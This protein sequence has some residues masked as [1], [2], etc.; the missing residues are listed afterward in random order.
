MNKGPTKVGVV[1]VAFNDA[2]FIKPL[3]ES[4]DQEVGQQNWEIVVVDNSHATLFTLG[5]LRPGVRIFPRP[6]NPGYA[7]SVNVGI[8][9]LLYQ[10]DC[11][12][13]L[14]LNPDA[15][16]SAGLAAALHFGIEN[17]IDV[18][19]PKILFERDLV[20]V[21]T[22]QI[23][24][25]VIQM[26]IVKSNQSTQYQSTRYFHRD[27]RSLLPNDPTQ[28][29]K[30]DGFIVFRPHDPP[31]IRVYTDESTPLTI[32]LQELSFQRVWIINNAGSF[33]SNYAAAGDIGFGQLDVGQFDS[34]GAIGA[35]CGAAV[36]FSRKVVQTVGA[37]DESFFLYYE[38][39]D[40]SLRIRNKGFPIIYFPKFT[41]THEHSSA[42]IAGSTQ[43]QTWVSQSRIRFAGLQAGFRGAVVTT[44]FTRIREREKGD[45]FLFLLGAAISTPI[46]VWKAV[47]PPKIR[48]FQ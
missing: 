40:W 5:D 12:W 26:K 20:A 47:K 41:V 45:R 15:R 37:M 44:V 25:N 21:D 23:S 24:Q 11:D 27:G 13:I 46:Q 9:Y 19:A 30:L 36:L 3:V 17:G 29:L 16:L 2:A 7:T 35:F 42:T 39:I 38:D 28:Q 6:D 10:T 34:V 14:I 32:D 33:I 43:W 4:L 22:R 18:L 48:F 8:E 1:V 31:T